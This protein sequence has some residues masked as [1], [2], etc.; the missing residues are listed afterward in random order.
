[1]SKPVIVIVPGAWH[2]PQHYKYI[3]EGLQKFHYEA[4]GVTLP[5]VDSNPPLTSWDKDAEAVRTEI[6]KHLDA[7]KDII[8][9]AHSY[10]G[11]VMSEA[12]RGLGKKAREEQGLKTSVLRLIYMCAIASQEG[13]TFQEIVKPETDEELQLALQ[14]QKAITIQPVSTCLA[15]LSTIT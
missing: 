13:K 9:I 2:R 15:R 7:G 14:Q 4:V 6:L 12:V 11:L 8:V 1:M 10:G 3:I 5:T